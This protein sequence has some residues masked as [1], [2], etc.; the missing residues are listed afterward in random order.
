M[1]STSA[2]GRFH[3]AVL[4]ELVDDEVHEPNLVGGELGV[5]K[6]LLERLDD[7]RAV[8]AHEIAHEDAKAAT[9]FGGPGDVDVLATGRDEHL[10]QLRQVVGSQLLVASKAP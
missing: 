6:V 10:L 5:V 8:E 2:S 3:H 4:R 1:T 9:L 7:R